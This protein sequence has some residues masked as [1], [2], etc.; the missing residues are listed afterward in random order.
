MKK[1]GIWNIKKIKSVNQFIPNLVYS[2]I[3]R[4]ILV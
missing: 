3:I 2:P 1:E 4:T